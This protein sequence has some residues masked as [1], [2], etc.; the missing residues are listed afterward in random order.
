MSVTDGPRQLSRDGERTKEEKLDY[1]VEKVRERG[2]KRVQ[3][4]AVRRKVIF[5]VLHE[6]VN[7]NG[8]PRNW[9]EE[10]RFWKTQPPN[11]YVC[12]K[13]DIRS[14]ES[15]NPDLNSSYKIVN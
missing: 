3:D 10:K 2:E 15:S 11:G 9:K 8:K 5:L 12:K 1:P 4:E 7:G 6:S 13:K 14:M